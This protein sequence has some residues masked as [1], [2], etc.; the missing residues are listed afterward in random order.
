MR[1]T[2][3]SSIPPNTKRVKES[4]HLLYQRGDSEA[5]ERESSACDQVVNCQKILDI[6]HSANS[7]DQNN[8]NQ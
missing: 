2:F 5:A 4:N 1:D 8:I 7:N 3:P 6:N